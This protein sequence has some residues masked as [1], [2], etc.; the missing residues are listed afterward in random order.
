MRCDEAMTDEERRPKSRSERLAFGFVAALLAAFFVLAPAVSGGVGFQKSAS[1]DLAALLA[2]KF[3][4]DRTGLLRD[5]AQE[6]IVA[7]WRRLAAGAHPYSKTAIAP[8]APA[9][10][11]AGGGLVPTDGSPRIIVRRAPERVYDPQ[12]P[13]SSAIV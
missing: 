8:S 6:K 9:I 11:S 13:P 3:H 10:Q 1:V 5:L 7:N 4:A 2:G 12:G